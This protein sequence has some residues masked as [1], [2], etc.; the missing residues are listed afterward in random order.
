MG[1]KLG[2]HDKKLKFGKQKTQL[3]FTSNQMK[4]V[5]LATTC[6]MYILS[7]CIIY[8]HKIVNWLTHEICLVAENL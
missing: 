1:G 5:K 4:R 6:I 7:I 2:K 8:L 3:I